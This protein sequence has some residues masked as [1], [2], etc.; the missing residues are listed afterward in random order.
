MSMKVLLEFLLVQEVVHVFFLGLDVV[1][2]FCFLLELPTLK[3]VLLVLILRRL[4]QLGGHRLKVLLYS[5]VSH[6]R[7][8]LS[9]EEP[10]SCQIDR[11][12]FADGGKH[13]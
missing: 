7:R 2:G 13:D 8:L 9:R 6:Q 10:R 11:G 4:S 12:V 1:E 5:V 3:V